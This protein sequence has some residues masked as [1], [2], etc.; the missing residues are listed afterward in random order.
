MA[1]GCSRG[2]QAR[3]AMRQFLVDHDVLHSLLCVTLVVL[4]PAFSAGSDPGGT[5]GDHIDV[6]DH[7]H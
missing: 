1:S 2:M 4:D 5:S 6:V 7:C 3:F